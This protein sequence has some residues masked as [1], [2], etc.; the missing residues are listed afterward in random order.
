MILGPSRFRERGP[1]GECHWCACVGE[2]SEHGLSL[3]HASAWMAGA[4]A[5]L[6]GNPISDNPYLGDILDTRGRIAL[7]RRGFRNSWKRGYEA[8]DS[9]IVSET[10][11]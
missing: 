11:T 7:G 4:H 10:T 8:A 3:P 5:R 6:A 2:R 9:A 1:Y